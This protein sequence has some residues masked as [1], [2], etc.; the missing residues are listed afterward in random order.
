MPNECEFLN[1]VNGRKAVIAVIGLGNTGL[2][3]V[4][5]YVAQGF[6]VHGIDI[7]AV[8]VAELRSGHCA[9]SHISD[10][11]VQT[12]IDGSF[13]VGSD[14]RAVTDADVV[15]VC[16]PTPLDTNGIAD[17]SAVRA[18]FDAMA[19]Y[20][21]RAPLVMVQSTV[22]PGT[23]D[24]LAARLA[25]KSGL[26]L[27]TDL[28]VASAPERIDPANTAGWSIT[29]TPRVV[30]GVTQACSRRASA[31]LES[32]CAKTT[33]VSTTRTAEV[34]KIVE[35]T[36][37][38]VNIILANEIS[39]VCRDLGVSERE[40]I[41]AAS[42]KP[43]GFL[44]HRPGPGIGGDC[45]PVTPAFLL[46]EAHRRGIPMPIV[47]TAYRQIARRPHYVVTR[48]TEALARKHCRIAGS[49]V[50][51][52]GVSYKENVNDTRNAPA[53]R[54]IERLL[55]LG[56][57]VQYHDPLVPVLTVSGRRLESQPCG[58]SDLVSYDCAVLVTAHDE[59]LSQLNPAPLPLVLDTRHVLR[60]EGNVEWL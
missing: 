13:S 22:P 31:V 4:Q 17:L 55:R 59:L 40:V 45:I 29:T 8:R 51:V 49:A 9:L 54:I 27:G 50:L 48:L 21:H 15:I 42:T 12:L 52:L 14:Y 33:T 53:V 35:N 41:E 28:F 57:S 43:F 56:A 6:P 10:Q 11:D 39:D 1:L 2:P 3:V 16:V 5:G 19:P 7:D 44:A 34:T 60:Q 32:L 26:T 46:V 18:A 20:L 36:F 25:A 38:M 58:P 47:A 30:G 23:T 24:I 37:R